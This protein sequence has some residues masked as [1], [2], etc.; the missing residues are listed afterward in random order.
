MSL[1]DPDEGIRM[2]E[3]GIEPGSCYTEQPPQISAS[4]F[5][6]SVTKSNI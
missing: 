5:N 6:P 3:L 4:P 2:W 1:Q